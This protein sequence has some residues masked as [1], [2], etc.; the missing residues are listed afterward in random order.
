MVF[1]QWQSQL[2][3]RFI[4]EL[5][6]DHV[7]VLTPPGFMVATTARLAWAWEAVVKVISKSAFRT[8]MSITRLAGNAYKPAKIT[9]Q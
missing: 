5:P 1:G 4:D 9:A 3:S 2:P 6:E 7:E 8:R